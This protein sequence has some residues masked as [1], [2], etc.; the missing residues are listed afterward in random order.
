M[1]FRHLLYLAAFTLGIAFQVQAADKKLVLTGSSTIAPLAL[2]LGKRFEKLHP[3]VLVDVQSGGSSRGVHDVLAGLADIGMVSR[4]LN[5]KERELHNQVIAFDGVAVI[6]HR[7]NPVKELSDEQI[8]AIYTGKI[9]NWKEVGGRDARI[10]V[11]NKAEGRSTLE[12]FLHYFSLKNSQIKAHVIIGDNQQGIKS[13]AGN[14]NAM[15]YVSVGTAEFEAGNGTAIRMIPMKKVIPSTATVRNGSFPL[16][17]P[18]NLVTKQVP[19]GLT[20]EFIEF[21]RSE[22]AADLVR[23]QFFVPVTR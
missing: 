6:L 8:V 5:A 14:P 4:A 13:V 23:A 2:E 7:D 9:S 12:L 21:A 16:V 10:T 11:V 18:L 3:G 1:N 15:G 20:K 19:T 17:R 22:K